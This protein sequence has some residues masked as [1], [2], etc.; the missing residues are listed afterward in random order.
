MLAELITPLCVSR[1]CTEKLTMPRVLSRNS[2]EAIHVYFSLMAVPV[3]CWVLQRMEHG[4]HAVQMKCCM[5]QLVR[6]LALCC[7]LRLV[8]LLA[9]LECCRTVQPGKRDF[10][11]C[12]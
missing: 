3:W 9:V 4:V 2:T 6:A 7:R 5:K 12:R 10:C 8:D 11:V 1:K